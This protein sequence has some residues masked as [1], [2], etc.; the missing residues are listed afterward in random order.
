MMTRPACLFSIML[1]LLI[2]GCGD[3]PAPNRD[4]VFPV[5][6]MVTYKGRPVVGADVT[7]I[8]QEKDRGA[9]GRTDSKGSFQL[10]T[11]GA[12]DGAV[13]GKHTVIVSLME[14]TE[15]KKSVAPIDSPD[16]QPPSMADALRAPRPKSGLPGKYGDMKTSDLV[17]DV[18]ADGNNEDVKIELKD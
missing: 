1:G 5:R 10:T 2:Q 18:N 14:S 9:F 3:A 7:F 6:G 13:A 4:P 8:C 12:N 16:Y 17:V 15:A 11:F